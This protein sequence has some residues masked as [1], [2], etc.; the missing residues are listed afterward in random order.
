MRRAEQTVTGQNNA[1]PYG[2]IW[3]KASETLGVQPVGSQKTYK[4][5]QLNDGSER[6]ISWD[7]TH[8]ELE[9][10]RK[11]GKNLIHEGTMDPVYGDQIKGPKHKPLRLSEYDG[12][13]FERYV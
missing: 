12:L 10:W 6:F 4:R 5:I 13:D 1:K 8:G 9:I 3:E 11:Q 7:T 2:R